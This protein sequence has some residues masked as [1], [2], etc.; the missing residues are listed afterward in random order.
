MFEYKYPFLEKME[1]FYFLYYFHWLV[2]SFLFVVQDV[3]I[4][5]Y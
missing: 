2:F 3:L 1:L 4:F 5:G